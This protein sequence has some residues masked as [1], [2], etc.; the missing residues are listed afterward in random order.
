MRG[1]IMRM[2]GWSGRQSSFSQSVSLRLP[3]ATRTTR[4]KA[5]CCVSPKLGRGTRV[6]VRYCPSLESNR[7]TGLSVISRNN[8]SPRVFQNTNHS[9]GAGGV[10]KNV[11]F[12]L[13]H[14]SK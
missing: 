12:Y 2:Q 14:V 1:A 7:I 11:Q 9:F 10:H 5:C 13:D 6:G 8:R 3:T 4:L